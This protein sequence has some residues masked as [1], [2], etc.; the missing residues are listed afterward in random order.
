VK[1]VLSNLSLEME[2]TKDLDHQPTL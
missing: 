2:K 1:K